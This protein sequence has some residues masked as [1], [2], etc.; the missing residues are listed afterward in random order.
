MEVVPESLMFACVLMFFLH[1]SILFLPVN[2]TLCT[3]EHNVCM[4]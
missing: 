1:H 3:S 4:M 2:K